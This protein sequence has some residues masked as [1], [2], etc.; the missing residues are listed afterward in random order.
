MKY[1]YWFVGL[2]MGPSWPELRPV[3][4]EPYLKGPKA[5]L[6]PTQFHIIEGPHRLNLL[7][8]S[9]VNC[10]YKNAEK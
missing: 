4:I 7:R 2:V 6:G 3:A 10:I 8:P 5:L 9:S 1:F